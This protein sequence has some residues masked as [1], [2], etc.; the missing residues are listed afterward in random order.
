MTFKTRGKDKEFHPK[1]LAN[2]LNL[3]G[4]CSWATLKILLIQIKI[5]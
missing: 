1:F 3:Q 2:S 4:V 5:T